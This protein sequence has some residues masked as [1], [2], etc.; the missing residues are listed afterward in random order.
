MKGLHQYFPIVMFVFHDF[1]V[2]II[3]KFSTC[4]IKPSAMNPY[5]MSLII[6]RVETG[7]PLVIPKLCP[8][9]SMAS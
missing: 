1:E 9:S 6:W 5:Q 8:S 4:V 2:D 7:V 3:L